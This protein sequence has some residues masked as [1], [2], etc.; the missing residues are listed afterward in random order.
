MS[1]RVAAKGPE[2]PLG[3]TVRALLADR[4]PRAFVF[5]LEGVLLGPAD[6]PE[7]RRELVGLLEPLAAAC[8][9]AVA[10]VSGRPLAEVDRLLAPLCLPGW[11]GDGNEVRPAGGSD[12]AASRSEGWRAFLTGG[13]FAGRTPV[14]FGCRG[15]DDDVYAAARAVGGTAIQVGPRA[16]HDAHAEVAG[17]NDV[18][19]L[20]RDFLADLT[21]RPQ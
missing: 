16:G 5:A 4:R 2:T 14:V 9:G 8:D 19:W 12:G 21:D 3:V 7:E 6:G 1:G 20:V 13:A 15:V 18:R 10:V 11:G 17:P